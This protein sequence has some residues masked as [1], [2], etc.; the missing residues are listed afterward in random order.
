MQ[1]NE[2][3][4][5]LKNVGLVSQQRIL[6]AGIDLNIQSG[7]V[8]AICGP[9]GSG[10]TSLLELMGQLKE[11]QSG[12]MHFLG[13]KLPHYTQL[14][15][16]HRTKIAMVFQDYNLF[17]H[18]TILENCMLS[19]C[20]VLKQDPKAVEKKAVE[21]LDQVQLVS[22]ADRYPHQVSGGQRQRAA[23]VRSLMLNPKILLMD[24][25]TSALDPEMMIEVVQ[26]IENLSKQ[27]MTMVISTHD[28]YLAKQIATK[29]VFI[30]DG[31]VVEQNDTQS[32]FNQPKTRRLKRFLDHMLWHNQ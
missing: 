9:S 4:L 18:L 25:P 31:R 6:L 3:I 2:T 12:Y 30:D 27:G 22:C 17:P 16:H 14:S 24:E 28:L 19:P 15:R 26:L 13:Q 23:I 8:I 5:E 7:D 11:Y 29:M 32:F 10:K 20:K 1:T 21:I